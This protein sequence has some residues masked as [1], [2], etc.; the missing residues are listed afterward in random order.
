MCV[1]LPGVFRNY[2]QTL[3]FGMTPVLQQ[4]ETT[5][6]KKKWDATFDGLGFHEV[7]RHDFDPGA[8]FC[9]LH[10]AWEIL[11]DQPAWRCREATLERLNV[12]AAA[13]ANVHE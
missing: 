1:R 5:R 10:G 8:R 9:V 7:V 12:L 4:E 2:Q 13:A 3:T 11:Q 6:G